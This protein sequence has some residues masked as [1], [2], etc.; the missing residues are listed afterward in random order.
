MRISGR[1]FLFFSF[2]FYLFTFC[3]I[4]PLPAQEK[5]VR[6]GEHKGFIVNES[7]QIFK[8]SPIKPGQT[9][10]VFLTPQW[11]GETSGRLEWRLQDP[12]G[13][14]LK[15]GRMTNPEVEPSLMEW[16]SNS[17]PKPSAYHI[18][19]RGSGGSDPGE[20]LGQYTLQIYLWDQNDANSGTDAP[21]TYEKA[22]LLPVSEP[23]TYLFNEN[24]VSSTADVYD[25]FKIHIKPN[26]T[27]TLRASPLQWQGGGEK[28]K[29]RWKFL[30]KSLQMWKEGNCLFHQT[31]PFVVRVF[32]PQVK[33]D[34]KPALFY[35]LVQVEGEASL[36]YTL[37]VETKEGR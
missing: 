13:P 34:P 4:T 32:H 10:Q 7:H 3:F 25:I 23:G 14:T 6:E 11:I 1:N 8:V 21:E 24:F 17:Q 20:I 36:I 16:T 33:K 9:I 5:I 15:A 35:L 27:L 31:T 2:L 29:L 18:H 19:I 28:G 37:Q 30:K 12:D 22:I 26:H